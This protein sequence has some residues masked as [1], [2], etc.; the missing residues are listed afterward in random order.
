MKKKTGLSSIQTSGR[1]TPIICPFG[2]EGGEER[3]GLGWAAPPQA[4]KLIGRKE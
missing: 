4:L 1:S 2:F 3:Q